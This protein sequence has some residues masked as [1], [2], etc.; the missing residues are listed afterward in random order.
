MI[1]ASTTAPV[2]PPVVAPLI[3]DPP[4]TTQAPV[5]QQ[6]SAPA[7]DPPPTPVIASPVAQQPVETQSSP[8]TNPVM[9]PATTP[10][11]RTTSGEEEK[12]LLSAEIWL[13]IAASI[14]AIVAVFVGW[15][16]CRNRPADTTN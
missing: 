15:M 2:N 14:L 1:C 3:V 16:R 11:L 13:S 8:P 10:S 4:T 6:S 5:Q 7:S 9:Q 12:A